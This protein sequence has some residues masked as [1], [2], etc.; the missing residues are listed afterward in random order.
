[1]KSQPP[2]QTQCAIGLYTTI[3]QSVM[4]IRYAEKRMRS[5]TA[6]EIRAAVI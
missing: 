1:L 5:T 2:P 6:P 4:K 3:A